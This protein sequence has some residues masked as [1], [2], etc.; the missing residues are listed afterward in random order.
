MNFS[1]SRLSLSFHINN[2]P[3]LTVG[4]FSGHN[5]Y[6]FRKIR[7]NSFFSTFFLSKNPK[8]D[9]ISFNSAYFS[10]FLDTSI[11]IV[12]EEN[13][14]R[15]VFSKQLTPKCDKKIIIENSQFINCKTSGDGGAV[16]IDCPHSTSI[17]KNTEFLKCTSI[18]SNYGAVSFPSMKSVA[19][20]STCFVNCTAL[21]QFQTFYANVSSKMA[22]NMT[23]FHYCGYNAYA[24]APSSTEYFHNIMRIEKGIQKVSFCNFSRNA[25]RGQCAAFSSQYPLMGEY[26]YLNIERNIGGY[27]FERYGIADNDENISYANIIDHNGESVGTMHLLIFSKLLHFVFR[28]ITIDP[29][30]YGDTDSIVVMEESVFD[31]PSIKLRILSPDGI[32]NSILRTA[33]CTFGYTKPTP[34][35]FEQ[36]S[37]L[38]CIEPEIEKKNNMF[39]SF[40]VVVQNP[41]ILGMIFCGLL[42]CFAIFAY[43]YSK[44]MIEEP[45]VPIVLQ[46]NRKLL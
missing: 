26:H 11:S 27:A 22:L 38:M 31:V 28:N 46:R 41:H 2:Y 7:A 3:Y 17:I 23:G 19:I 18:N 37:T 10:N 5:S 13:I 42:F 24:N 21:K 35:A 9:Q 40:L 33:N 39:I 14:E 12:N 44:N 43:C 4:K 30:I 25:V 32:A 36:P 16:L 45:K 29:F 15:S 1:L 34:I 20:F 6:N 8:F